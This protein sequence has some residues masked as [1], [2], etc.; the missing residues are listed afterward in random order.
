MAAS[1]FENFHIKDFV[2]KT[3]DGHDIETA[4]CVPKDVA[5]GKRPV[6]VHLHGGFLI[7]GDKMFEPW[8]AKW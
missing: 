5:Q 7:I 3:V 2:Y 4:V 1:K 6:L 8:W